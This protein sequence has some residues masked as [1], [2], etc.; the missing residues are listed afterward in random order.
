M[1]L[2]E[3][4]NV[5]NKKCND[6]W[7][8]LKIMENVYGQKSLQAEKALTKWVTYDDIFRELYNESP[9]YSVL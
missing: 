2:E 8:M 4:K 1:K 3:F 6:S 9:L 5:L 7:D